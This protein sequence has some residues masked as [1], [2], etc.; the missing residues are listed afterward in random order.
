MAICPFFSPRL[1]P[2]LSGEHRALHCLAAEMG[3]LPQLQEAPKP[4]QKP[5][6]KSPHAVLARLITWPLLSSVLSQSLQPHSLLSQIMHLFF[7]PHSFCSSWVSSSGPGLQL[8]SPDL[9][10]FPWREWQSHCCQR[11]DF[12]PSSVMCLTSSPWP[13]LNFPSPFLWLGREL[14]LGC[15]I[16]T[17]G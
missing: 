3:K 13:C 15:I 12:K 10:H 14:F 17:L 9:V 1:C 5:T 2:S 4:H 6:R 11:E 8:K 16:K 7:I